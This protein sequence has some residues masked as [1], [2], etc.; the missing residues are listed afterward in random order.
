MAPSDWMGDERGRRTVWNVEYMAITE[1]RM[2]Q[3][4]GVGMAGN[5]PSSS[6]GPLPH[7][8]VIPVDPR[9]DFVFSTLSLRS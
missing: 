3:S 8:G 9:N 2:R 1:L 7:P 6:S 4:R 5:P